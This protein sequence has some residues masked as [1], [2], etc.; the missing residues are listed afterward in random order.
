MIPCSRSLC[1]DKQIAFIAYGLIANGISVRFPTVYQNYGNSYNPTTGEFTC[2]L[3]GI[4]HFVTTLTKKWDT[5]TD[6]VACHLYH[7][8]K[9]LV[10]AYEDPFSSEEDKGVYSYTIS[11]TLHL[12][13]GDIV[14]VKCPHPSYLQS[15]NY[16]SFTGFLIVSDI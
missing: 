10:G 12:Q 9:E 4:Y 15:N 8:S 5:L 11:A 13:R 1:P 2:H 7:N 16:C 6:Y 3:P 14:H